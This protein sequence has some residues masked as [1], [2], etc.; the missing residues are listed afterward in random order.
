LDVKR[1]A[2]L[3]LLALVMPALGQSN[4]AVL[5]GSVT[6]PQQRPV[7][8]ASVQL[9]ALA[10]GAVRQVVTNEQGL[11][12]APGLLPGDYELTAQAKN[13]A[14]AVQKL[15]LEV[16]QQLTIAIALKLAS[17]SQAVEVAARAEVLHT[18]DASV[19]EVVEPTSIQNLPLNGRMLVDLVLTVPG[20]H[21]GFGA[22]EGDQ[23]PLYWRPGQR[24]AVVISG[25]R[26]NANLFLLDGVTNTD[27]TFNTQNLSPSPDAVQ[28]FQVQTS[29]YSADMGG[30]GGGQINIVT[31]SGTARYHGTVYEFLRNSA[32]DASTFASMGN[33]HLVQND[34]AL[35]WAAPCGEKRP[36]SL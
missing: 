4:Y 26:P 23:N 25:S 19:G 34:L 10:T 29:S 13:F 5:S 11:F 33:N 31:H 24:S 15:R 30:A 8:G 35:R 2:L 12:D 22:Q 28:E 27:P 7:A 1:L 14:S 6:D 17:V 9:K 32:L 20:A 36:S 3:S 18:T 16:G 21:L